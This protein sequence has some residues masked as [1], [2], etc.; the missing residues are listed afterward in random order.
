MVD[1]TPAAAGKLQ[2]ILVERGLAGYG[3]RVF[4][5]G[6]SCSGMQYGMGFDEKS[7][8]GD[9][10]AT[11]GGMTVFVDADSAQYLEGATV[12]FVDSETGGG[13]KIDNPNAMSG[14]NC[15]SGG[16]SH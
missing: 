14:C 12:D 10:I 5:S 2:D 7:R 13:F 8:E 16:C 1:L 3:L 4:V 6:S 9:T 11:V 15:G